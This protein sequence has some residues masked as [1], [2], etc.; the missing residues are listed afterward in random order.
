MEDKK[1]LMLW[2]IFLAAE[3]KHCIRLFLFIKSDRHYKVK[4]DLLQTVYSLQTLWI[5]VTY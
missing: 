1:I 3:V 4:K 2:I 5:K